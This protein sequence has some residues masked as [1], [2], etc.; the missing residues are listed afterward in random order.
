M[1]FSFPYFFLERSGGGWLLQLLLLTGALVLTTQPGAH[2]QDVYFSQPFA[3][4]LHTNPAFAGLL[5]DYS[6]TLAFRNQFPTLTGSFRSVQLAADLR[7]DRPRVP[8][9]HHGYGLLLNRD[10][11]GTGTYVRLEAGGIYSY[12]TR[13]T[14]QFALAAGVR[15]SYG[16]QSI[17]YSNLIFGDQLAADGSALGPTAEALNGR[18][19]N[20][21]TVGLGTV[22]YSENAWLSLVGQHLNQ[23]NL[24]F[25]K[26]KTSLPLL[27]GISGGYKVF[28]NKPGPG[29][30]PNELSF[31]PV[32]GFT[33]QGGS[34]RW[35]TGLYATAAPITLGAV[36][37]NIALGS[38]VARQ[39]ALALVVG[40]QTGTL[41]LGYSYDAALSDLSAEVG[42]AHEVTLGIRA[43]DKLENAFRRLKRRDYPLAPCPAF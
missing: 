14:R 11:S 24:A 29:K 2:A 5:D 20:Y 3:T 9:Q 31:T 13:L 40:V 27:L 6:V 28:I 32:A 42:G 34:Q 39:Q 36:Y 38:S 23:P 21:L 1:V 25:Q 35:E 8:G 4:R 18:A 17:D 12:H 41:R 16:R 37:R 43:F 10:R 7:P 26:P 30:S 19:A 15:A 33:Q 22:L